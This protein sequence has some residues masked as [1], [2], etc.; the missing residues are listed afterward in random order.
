[1]P[2]TC[3]RGSAATNSACSPTTVQDEAGARLVAERLRERIDGYV[4]A[5]EQQT[6]TIS[7]SIGGV[8]LDHPT[9]TLKDLFAQAD[10]ACYM[11]KESGRNRVHFYSEQDDETTRRR[12][13]ME[14]ANRLRWAIEE[15]RLQLQ[16]QEVWPLTGAGDP[17]RAG[18]TAGRGSSC[19]CGSATRR[20]AW[21]CPVRSCRRPSAT[22]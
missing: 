13:E 16:Y 19:C 7:A 22:A 4:F 10:T 12:S 18:A 11:A 3:S 14:W 9:A 1:M 21:S 15:E 6:F 20:G 8:M 5:W 17:W 2:A